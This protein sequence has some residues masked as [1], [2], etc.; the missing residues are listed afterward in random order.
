MTQVYVPLEIIEATMATMSFLLRIS[1]PSF[2]PCKSVSFEHLKWC[3]V[4]SHNRWIP[5]TFNVTKTSSYVTKTSFEVVVWPELV[6]VLLSH[7]LEW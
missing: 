1:E 4:S 6:P 2:F 3:I 7:F 5:F